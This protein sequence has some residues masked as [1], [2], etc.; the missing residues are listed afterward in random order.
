MGEGI[1]SLP[2]PLPILY[3]ASTAAAK[4]MHI[5]LAKYSTEY[6]I[7]IQNTETHA[8]KITNVLAFI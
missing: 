2:I 4:L 6:S 1:P 8:Q 7:R 3:N 5:Q